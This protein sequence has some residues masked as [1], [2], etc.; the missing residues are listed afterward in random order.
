MYGWTL[1]LSKLTK[2]KKKKKGEPYFLKMLSP[3]FYTAGLTTKLINLLII[4]KSLKTI[5]KI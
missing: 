4:R 2:K 1:P 5:H 3:I